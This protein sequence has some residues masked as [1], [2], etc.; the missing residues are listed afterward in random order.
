MKF[1]FLLVSF[2]IVANAMA[3]QEEVLLQKVKAKLDKVNDYQAEGKM[4]LDVSFINA[5]ASNVTVYYKKPNHFKVKKN[6]G[7]SILPKGGVSVNMNSLLPSSNYQTV[8][9]GAS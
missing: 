1:V 4:K 7:I 5:P 9:G 8:P 2:L 3:Q 6:G